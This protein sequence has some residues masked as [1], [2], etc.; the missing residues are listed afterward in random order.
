M[1]K[2]TN[3]RKQFLDA[4]ET[5][6]SYTGDMKESSTLPLMSATYEYFR[7]RHLENVTEFTVEEEAL[8]RQ[9]LSTVFT[10]L[11]KECGLSYFIQRQGP[12]D[13]FN[14]ARYR[15]GCRFLIDDVG[16]FVPDGL[17]KDENIE[18]MIDCFEYRAYLLE[19]GGSDV[20]YYDYPEE[21]VPEH[22]GVPDT[23][24]WWKPL[25]DIYTLVNYPQSSN[26]T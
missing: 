18:E 26:S 8:L 23:H 11:G 6:F 13:V 15:S 7:S 3:L 19:L 16:K 20:E 24:V 4:L 1:S 10:K 5:I 14:Y 9:Q 17:E 22:E 21:P 25:E 2:L 12:E